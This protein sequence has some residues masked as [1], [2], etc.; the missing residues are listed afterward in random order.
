MYMIKI[1]KKYFNK[2]KYNKT[3]TISDNWIQKIHDDGYCVVENFFSEQDLQ[4]LENEVDKIEKTIDE[5]G[6]KN[7]KINN[8]AFIN[9]NNGLRVYNMDKLSNAINTIF[10]KNKLFTLLVDSYHG[11]KDNFQYT[12][13]QKTGYYPSALPNDTYGTGWH[14]DDYKSSIKVFLYL[15]DVDIDNGPFIFLPKSHKLD[16]LKLK[17]CKTAFI[18]SDQLDRYMS[19]KDITRRCIANDAITFTAKKGT[20][21]IVDTIGWHTAGILK[22]GTRKVLVN[23]YNKPHFKK[24]TL[25]GKV[26]WPEI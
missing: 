20:I 16:S 1:K 25:F 15:S 3:G 12:M 4:K 9:K 23:Y 24:V 10:A 22:S 7:L 18:N 17:Y 19:K 2:K 21:I 6:S 14:F 11:M 8:P 13:Y 26:L 5:D